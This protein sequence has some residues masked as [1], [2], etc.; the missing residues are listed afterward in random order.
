MSATFF[1]LMKYAA[2]GIAAPSMT[3][4]DKMRALAMAGGLSV[5]SITGVPPITFTGNGKPLKSVDIFGNTQQTGTPTPYAPIM[6]TFCGKLVGTDWTIP[7]SCAGQTVPVYLGQTQTVRRVKKLVLTGDETL[8]SGS[9]IGQIRAPIAGAINSLG[10]C[11]HYILKAS[12]G[13][14]FPYIRITSNVLWFELSAD[15]Y[16]T[17]E[18]ALAAFKSY[19]SAQYAAGTPVTVWY[20]L[21]EPETAI[22]NEPLAK[23]GDYTDELNSAIP[24]PTVKG[25]NL[26]TVDT[27]LQPSSMTIT[28][29]IKEV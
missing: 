26:L 10:C 8:T 24:I 9:V 20:V 28:G 2:T 22:V 12:Y 29:N 11:T 16:E 1:D 6:P 5:Q 17:K 4:F 18:E 14:A 15:G 7:I 25:Q 21:A 27:D 3:D 19:L 13:G 23:I